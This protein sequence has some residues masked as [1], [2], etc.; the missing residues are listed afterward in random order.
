MNHEFCLRSKGFD[1]SRYL[2]QSFDHMEAG[3]IY[4]N[5]DDEENIKDKDYEGTKIG[6]LIWMN[7]NMALVMRDKDTKFNISYHRMPT[8]SNAL[9]DLGY[10]HFGQETI[11]ETGAYPTPD[12]MVLTHFGISTAWRKKGIGER[13]LKNLIKLM[14]GKYKYLVIL[15]SEPLQICEDAYTHRTYE[16]YNVGLA[17]LE[18]DPEKA[19]WKLNAFC[20][21]CGFR[22]FKNYENVFICNVEQA[23]AE[24]RLV[25]RS[26]SN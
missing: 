26:E 5:K 17:G 10:D 3:I 4:V 6:F 12:L 18:K 9:I 1:I 23:V 11:A 19:Q 21:R 20:Q 2:G 14:E 13:V 8:K 16:K 22:L 15:D 25:A 7:F 24:W